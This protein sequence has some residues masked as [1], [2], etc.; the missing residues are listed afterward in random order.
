MILDFD[1]FTKQT[2]SI[3]M[4]KISHGLAPVSFLNEFKPKNVRRDIDNNMFQLPTINTDYKKRFVTY[5]GILIWNSLPI[6]LRIERRFPVF[7]SKLNKYYL[8]SILD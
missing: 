6:Q 7:K 5:S 4:W 8:N 3:F 2:I 1:R